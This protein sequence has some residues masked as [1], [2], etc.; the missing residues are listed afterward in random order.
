MMWDT[1]V[2]GA[3]IE[4]SSAAYS[5]AQRG[6]KT[7]LLEQVHTV[8]DHLCT[9]IH[10]IYNLKFSFRRHRW[11]AISPIRPTIDVTVPWSDTVVCHV[12][13]LCSNGR[14]YRHNFFCIRQSHVSSDRIKIC[15]A[16]VNPYSPNFAPNWPTPCWCE[17]RRHC[18]VKCGRMV[19]DSAVVTM[20]S[21]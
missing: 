18:M 6:R 2:V 17:H 4:G 7:L 14:R 3:G 10:C 13:A 9:F 8:I 15:L 16:S 12:R 11:H 21:L 1:I 5:L 20:E 19:R